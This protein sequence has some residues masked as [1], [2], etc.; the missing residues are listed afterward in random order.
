MNGLIY[1]TLLLG[2]AKFEAKG[3]PYTSLYNGNIAAATYAIKPLQPKVI[4]YDY[5]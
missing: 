2:A 1:I 5:S 4:G 3:L